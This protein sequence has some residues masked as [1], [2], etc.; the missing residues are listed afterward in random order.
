[1][2]VWQVETLC[3]ECLEER[4]CLPVAFPP[5]QNIH[6]LGQDIGEDGAAAEPKQG[7]R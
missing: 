1:M 7:Q 2:I 6:R 4:R 5:L 3:Q